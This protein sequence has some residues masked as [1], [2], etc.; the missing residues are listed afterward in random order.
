M[1]TSGSTTEGL[2]LLAWFPL[3]ITRTVVVCLL[4]QISDQRG[5]T[6]TGK[7]EQALVNECIPGA[8]VA[9]KASN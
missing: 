7:S 6:G 4:K 2:E 1:T 3:R 5:G 9:C 8:S